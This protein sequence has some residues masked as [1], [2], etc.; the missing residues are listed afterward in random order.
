MEDESKVN[1]QYVEKSSLDIQ[2]TDSTSLMEEI[3]HNEEITHPSQL[4]SSRRDSITTIQSNTSSV[5]KIPR[6]IRNA[7]VSNTSNSNSNVA[8]SVSSP[9]Q[10]KLL[11]KQQNQKYIK[12]GKE[13]SER[14]WDFHKNVQGNNYL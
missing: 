5:S 8:S 11:T 13:P 7:T 4:P 14:N 9:V 10:R 1:A 3:G 12:R 2:K 6:Y